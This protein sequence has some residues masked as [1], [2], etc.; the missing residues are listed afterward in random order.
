[1]DFNA[2]TAGGVD[3]ISCAFS[4]VCLAILAQYRSYGCADKE[5]CYWSDLSR[6]PPFARWAGGVCYG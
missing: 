6:I 3:P 4:P 5:N 1:M 2:E